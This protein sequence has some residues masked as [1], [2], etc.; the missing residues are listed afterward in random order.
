MT[1][2]SLLLDVFWIEDDLLV[3]FWGCFCFLM[4]YKVENLLPYCWTL[5]ANGI[6]QSNITMNWVG[7]ITIV[8]VDTKH[9]I[10]NIKDVDLNYGMHIKMWLPPPKSFKLNVCIMGEF[11][12]VPSI[13]VWQRRRPKPCC[14]ASKV[15][16][17][18]QATNQKGC[19]GIGYPLHLCIFQLLRWVFPPG[20]R[21]GRS[22]WSSH[23]QGC[24]LRWRE[25]KRYGVNSS[26]SSFER[27]KIYGH[28]LFNGVFFPPTTAIFLNEDDIGTYTIKA[29]DD[30]RTL[31][32]VL[33][34]RP[35]ANI[36][37]HNEL[38]SLW[39]K[40]VGKTFERVYV[41]EEEV[42]KQIQGA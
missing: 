4:Y 25:H 18:R 12:E 16:L 28:L 1:D 38:I 23:G 8:A 3:Q 15:D 32:K 31:N 34:L 7:I 27:C 21:T 41:P 30:P 10:L 22:H 11:A 42:L 9:S 29:V 5:S 36:L 13:G 39:E 19:W 14:G 35:S 6:N 33:Y 24:H 17:C 20:I 40:K 2:V 26:S 37:S